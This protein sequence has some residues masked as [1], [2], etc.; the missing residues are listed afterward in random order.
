M[1]I[2]L[3]IDLHEVNVRSQSTYEVDLM[4]SVSS[5]DRLRGMKIDIR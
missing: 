2:D 3:K 4:G 5:Y 1:E